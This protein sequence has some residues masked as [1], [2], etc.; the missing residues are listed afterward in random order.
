MGV[1]RFVGDHVPQQD[2]QAEYKV[3]NV[4]GH[5]GKPERVQ[6][7]RWCTQTPCGRTLIFEGVGSEE[8][9][10]VHN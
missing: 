7:G 4:C 9:K 1:L 8:R 5:V 10:K 6:Q 3:G 2:A